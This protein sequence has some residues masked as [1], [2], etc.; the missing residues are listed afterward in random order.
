M[1]TSEIND[2]EIQP[3]E[4]KDQGVQF[5]SSVL[6]VLNDYRVRYVSEY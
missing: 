5:S 2:I 1:N 6:T 4:F 3:L